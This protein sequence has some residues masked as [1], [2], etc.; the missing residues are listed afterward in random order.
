MARCGAMTQLIATMA[1]RFAK[2]HVE[3]LIEAASTDAGM[4]W[5]VSCHDEAYNL[6]PD[7]AGRD[8]EGC[9]TAGTVFAAEELLLDLAVH[10]W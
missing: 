10:E 9:D 8:C 5:C 4:G 1:K 3:Q 6:E 7:A 2:A